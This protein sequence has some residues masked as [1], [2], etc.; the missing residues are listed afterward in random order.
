MTDADDANISPIPASAPSQSCED[1]GEDIA[2]LFAR[3][4]H[5][6]D[7]PRAL[8][9]IAAATIAASQGDPNPITMAQSAAMLLDIAHSLGGLAHPLIRAASEAV[10]PAILEATYRA[11][12]PSRTTRQGI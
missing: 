1:I 3:G 6:N 12:Q 8:R 4:D 5:W 10:G 11:G 9:R 7:L 2:A